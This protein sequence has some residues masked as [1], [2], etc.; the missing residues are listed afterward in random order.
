MA[1]EQERFETDPEVLKSAITALREKLLD[2]MEDYKN[3]PI[4]IEVEMAD[5]RYVTRANPFLQEYRATIK[6]YAAALKAYKE[7]TGEDDATE[8][9]Q[10]ADLRSRFMVAK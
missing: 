2:G 4:T 1:K 8:V 10:L 7:L 9:D 6:D 3:E 5:R